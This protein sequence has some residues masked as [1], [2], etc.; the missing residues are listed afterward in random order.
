[1]VCQ[2]DATTLQQLLVSVEAGRPTPIECGRRKELLTKLNSAD[3]DLLNEKIEEQWLA[4]IA[5]V[6][7]TIASAL[8]PNPPRQFLDENY[9]DLAF[10]LFAN[11]LDKTT[12]R[13]LFVANEIHFDD[14]T[15][16]GKRYMSADDK[17][18]QIQH[19]SKKE[20]E[21]F[22]E[23][24][25]AINRKWSIFVDEQDETFRAYTPKDSAPQG[26]WNRHAYDIA[27]ELFPDGLLQQQCGVKPR[28]HPEEHSLKQEET[29]SQDQLMAKLYLSEED[30]MS[31]IRLFSKRE[32]DRFFELTNAVNRKWSIFMEKQDEAFRAYAPK[33]SA[34]QT[35]WNKH[36][37]DIAMDLFPNSFLQHPSGIK[38]KVHPKEGSMTP[39]E[40]QSREQLLATLDESDVNEI[41]QRV[42]SKWQTVV[43]ST[44]RY[45]NES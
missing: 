44:Q 34:P 8:P 42:R 39:E 17:M 45:A 11:K 31:Q 18:S 5:R 14:K 13:P 22:F 9:Y 26:F 3:I 41:E 16:I 28:V 25:N 38:P 29:Q 7:E 23:L 1:M 35:F 21:R 43:E 4:K 15:Q 33:D 6:D 36:A 19:L 2:A 27:M 24:T 20:P 32:P 37:Y 30:K 12:D 10:T 40:T